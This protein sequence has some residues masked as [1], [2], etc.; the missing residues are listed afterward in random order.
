M[1][2]HITNRK[3]SYQTS[4]PNDS[5]L[6]EGL[7]ASAYIVGAVAFVIGSLFFL[8][9]FEKHLA[10]G[11]WLFI[12]G[13]LIYLAVTANDC[14]EIISHYRRHPSH[15]TKTMLEFVMSAGYIIGSVLFLVGSA[16]F[17]PSVGWERGGAWCFIIGSILF[18]IGATVNVTQITQ[19]GNIVVLQLLNAVAISFII[20]SILFLVFSI[21][22]LWPSYQTPLA[23]TLHT[24]LGAQFIFASM[25][26]LAGGIVNFY[27]AYR[28]HQDHQKKE[29]VKNQCLS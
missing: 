12:L 13:S 14:V 21:P 5:F 9:A 27:R 10:A 6:W 20:G 25:L 18:T 26:F 8:P 19:A 15:G 3:R 24:Y 1:P 4:L 7:N 29:D 22:Y 17:L 11:A 23:H 2:H 28:A 16:L